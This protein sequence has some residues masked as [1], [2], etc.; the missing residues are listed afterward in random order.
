M[1]VFMKVFSVKHQQPVSQPEVV[2]YLIQD[3]DYF[4]KRSLRARPIKAE[5]R[6]FS[7]SQPCPAPTLN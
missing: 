1:V 6:P 2:P 3:R 5:P 7:L 4:N